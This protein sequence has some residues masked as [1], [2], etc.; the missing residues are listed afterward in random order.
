[1]VVAS[2][3]T[4]TIVILW[5]TVF[6]FAASAAE[7]PVRVV[8]TVSPLSD[9]VR[10]IGG[11]H[12]VVSTVLAPGMYPSEYVFREG[13][14]AR[15]KGTELVVRIGEGGDPWSDRLVA[16]VGANVPVINAARQE[17]LAVAR[18]F[19]KSREPAGGTIPQLYVW[20]DPRIVRDRIAPA[21]LQALVELRPA[22]AAEFKRNSRRFFFELSKMDNET[23]ALL[24]QMPPKPF[25]AQTGAWN[26]F[27]NR[28][29]LMPMEVVVPDERTEI[30]PERL[31]RMVARGRLA[32]VHLIFRNHRPP[33]RQ[34]AQ[35]AKRIDATLVPLG[36]MGN[37][38]P[39]MM[40]GSY[41]ELMQ[42]NIRKLLMAFH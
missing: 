32:G 28:Y 7:G 31:S 18:R 40:S 37:E 13:Y 3:R 27:F 21:V 12:V 10:K 33:T 26:F 41:L 11:R 29:G 35:I 42:M 1:M 14:L 19:A 24:A 2:L 20:L 6:P 8:G 22:R 36:V 25:M 34:L 38:H 15:M 17:D 5:L 39:D 16:A 4:I 9:I 23:G 30:S